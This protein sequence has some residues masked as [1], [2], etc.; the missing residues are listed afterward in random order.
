MTN[1]VEVIN[2]LDV[3]D[4]EIVKALDNEELCTRLRSII[5][6]WNSIREAL[7][8]RD[9]AFTD[10]DWYVD[11]NAEKWDIN[12]WYFFVDE[13]EKQ[14]DYAVGDLWDMMYEKAAQAVVA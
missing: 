14:K 8:Y 3:S 9:T 13:M 5:Y 6:R 11:N 12:Q 7:N 2:A 1:L 10:E 4:D